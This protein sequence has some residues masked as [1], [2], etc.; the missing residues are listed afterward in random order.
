MRDFQTSLNYSNS[1]LTL[2][3]NLN[4]QSLHLTIKYAKIKEDVKEIWNYEDQN[5]SSF[6][7]HG[8]EKNMY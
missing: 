4:F 6:I 2:L 3:I 7:I 8:N 1:T 5:R